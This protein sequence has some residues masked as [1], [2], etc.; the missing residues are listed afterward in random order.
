MGPPEAAAAHEIWLRLGRLRWQ[1]V[2]LDFKDQ[3]VL[4][5]SAQPKPH[6]RP[7]SATAP[8]DRSP[9]VHVLNDAAAGGKPSGRLDAARSWIGQRFAG[10]ALESL[11]DRRVLL[12]V[13]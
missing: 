7:V 9:F 2:V 12:L 11:C 10:V 8:P 5:T 1:S 4:Q 6:T 13:G 3:V